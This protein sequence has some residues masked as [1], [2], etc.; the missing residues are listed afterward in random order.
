MK[1]FVKSTLFLLA[2]ALFFAGCKN[3]TEEPAPVDIEVSTEDFQSGNWLTDGTWFVD[4]SSTSKISGMGQNQEVKSTGHI[5]MEVEG[6][7]VTI[8]KATETVNGTEHDITSEM[9]AAVQNKQEFLESEENID[10][11]D[12]YGLMNNIAIEPEIHIYKNEAG[13]EYRLTMKF[14]V[15]YADMFAGTGI[16]VPEQLKDFTM[17]SETE[18]T[19][20][21]Q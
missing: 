18:A 15:N 12:P 17:E 7:N 8:T 21:K 2:A 1:K 6:D 4:E 9:Q 19:Y 20:K 5:E 3:Q 10:T 11:E 16:E 14:Q 13:T